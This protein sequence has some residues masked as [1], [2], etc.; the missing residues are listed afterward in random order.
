[1]NFWLL[2]TANHQKVACSFGVCFTLDALP[3]TILGIYPGLEPAQ[4]RYWL[5]PP[6][7][8]AVELPGIEPPT[9]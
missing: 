5:V 7:E 6:L 8:A 3:D 4:G 1:M 2:P 9:L